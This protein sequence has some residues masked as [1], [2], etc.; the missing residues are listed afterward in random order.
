MKYLAVLL[1][2]FVSACDS[3]YARDVTPAA[4]VTPGI[5]TLLADSAHLIA[6][7]RVGLITNHTGRDAAG[8]SSI[9]LL[10]KAP[11]VRLTALFAPE[12]GI[13]GIVDAN[14]PAEKDAATGLPIY[15]LYGSETE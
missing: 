10:F 5:T 7:K 12:H 11:G 13:R 9:D 6:G 14:V 8:K 4:A 2:V 15:S 1:A 3:S